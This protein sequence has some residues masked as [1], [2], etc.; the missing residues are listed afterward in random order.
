MTMMTGTLFMLHYSLQTGA[1]SR[2]LTLTF[3]TFVLFQLFNVFN[4]RVEEGSAFNRLFF[5]NPML[6][7]SLSAVLALQIIVMNLHPLQ[8]LF[9]VTSSASRIGCW[10]RV[11]LRPS[12]SS[13]KHGSS[14]GESCAQWG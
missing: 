10:L 4:A 5:D 14:G 7:W 9:N 8:I 1:E 11:L 13:R 3:T 6:W 2:A 12:S